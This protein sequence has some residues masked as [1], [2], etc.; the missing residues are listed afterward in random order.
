MGC[1]C[2]FQVP[3]CPKGRFWSS[4]RDAQK[5]PKSIEN[6]AQRSPKNPA[7]APDDPWMRSQNVFST[8]ESHLR[9]PGRTLDEILVGCF[10]NFQATKRAKGRFWG[11]LR[12]AQTSPKSIK[13]GFVA[14]KKPWGASP[15][16]FFIDLGCLPFSYLALAGKSRVFSTSRFFVCF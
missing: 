8:S 4:L 5:S 14:E 1:L 10:C 13:N 12:A 2:N 7:S 16:P 15:E 6:G 11:S 3:K 9:G